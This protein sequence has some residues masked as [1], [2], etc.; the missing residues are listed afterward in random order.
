MNCLT[1]HCNTNTIINLVIYLEVV[2]PCLIT[3]C[4]KSDIPCNNFGDPMSIR[5]SQSKRIHQI[6]GVALISTAV[7]I[8]GANN[9][10]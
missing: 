5:S 8:A 9:K 1:F 10:V 2:N 4:T 3:A 6:F 7:A